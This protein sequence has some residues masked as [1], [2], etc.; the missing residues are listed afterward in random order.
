MRVNLIELSILTLCRNVCNC[1]CEVG[2]NSV[3]AC[4][5]QCAL[6]CDLPGIPRTPTNFKN[7]CEFIILVI[8]L[9]ICGNVF[10]MVFTSLKKLTT[11]TPLNF[12]TSYF[13]W[14]FTSINRLTTTP[15]N[16]LFLMVFYL[17][18]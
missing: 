2:H 9:G 10:I 18:K 1:F 13:S 14:F 17:T 12:L 5:V 8:H 16:P 7:S 6:S 15:H 11:A 3:R 4:A